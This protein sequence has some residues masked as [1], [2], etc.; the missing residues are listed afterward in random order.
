[1]NDLHELFFC[2]FY[3]FNLVELFVSAENI[4]K[5][6]SIQR[7]EQDEFALESQKKT[8]N[9]QKLNLFDKEIVP[10]S[11]KIRGNIEVISKDEFPKP[12]TTYEGL[13]K[14]RPAFLKEGTVTAGNASGI[15]DG[16]A[17]LV[18]MSR[19]VAES[20]N[21]KQLAKIVGVAQAGVDPL[22]MG[23]G[24]VP[25]IRKLVS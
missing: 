18:L 9:A 11:V 25:A 10:V 5:Q 12:E 20:K 6:Y 15:N 22:I 1:M 14:L 19:K 17:A 16:A 13:S 2:V 21:V 4:A 24:P 7:N 23:I 3:F 8:E